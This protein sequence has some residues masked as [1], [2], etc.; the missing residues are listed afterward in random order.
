MIE[1]RR[2]HGLQNAALDLMK[3]ANASG[4]ISTDNWKDGEIPGV[5]DLK[6]PT[7]L[8]VGKPTKFFGVEHI[9]KILFT[10]RQVYFYLPCR[11]KMEITSCVAFFL[12]E[13]KPD[14]LARILNCL[15]SVAQSGHNIFHKPARAAYD[16]LSKK[17]SS[18]LENYRLGA[19]SCTLGISDSRGYHH[20][21]R[22]VFAPSIA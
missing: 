12:T 8:R 19:N 10:D 18:T 7:M 17:Y 14:D 3:R 6:S 16:I 22:I 11:G 2:V 4:E 1:K 15:K 9:P 5:L 21:S 13:I 20:L